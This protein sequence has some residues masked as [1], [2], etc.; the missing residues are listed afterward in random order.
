MP[1]DRQSGPRFD[2]A[3]ID[4]AVKA[5]L[6]RQAEVLADEA[7]RAERDEAI[8]NAIGEMGDDPATSSSAELFRL[9]FDELKAERAERV[10]MAERATFFESAYQVMSESL[11]AMQEGQLN[12]IAIKKTVR[13]AAKWGGGVAGLLVG[14][15]KLFGL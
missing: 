4:S 11:E 2:Q 3:A 15:A 14:L 7:E 12:P 1:D 8:E 9:L 5:A 13:K 6:E 10:A